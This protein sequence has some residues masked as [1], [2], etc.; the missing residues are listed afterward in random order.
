M[1]V[2]FKKSEKLGNRVYKAGAQEVPDSLAHNLA[3][4]VLVK[5]G[6]VSVPAKNE[7][8][9]KIQ[10]AKDA[11]AAQAAQDARKAAKAEAAPKAQADVAEAAPQ[12]AEKPSK[13][14]KG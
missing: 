4:K 2:I 9:Q 13:K 1:Q 7:A 12:A 8:Q 6:G 3:F 11:K 5:S 10:L 14:G